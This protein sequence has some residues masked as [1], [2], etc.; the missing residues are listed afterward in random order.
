[1]GNESSSDVAPDSEELPAPP[2]PVNR[3]ELQ[4]EESTHLTQDSS[5]NTNN[6]RSSSNKITSP[7]TD[8]GKTGAPAYT[9]VGTPPSTTTSITSKPIAPHAVDSKDGDR[10]KF[11][12][13]SVE[14]EFVGNDEEQ[15]TRQQSNQSNRGMEQHTG[16]EDKFTDF[17]KWM[18]KHGAQFPDQHLVKYTE[19]NR[20]VHA[21]KDISGKK[22]NNF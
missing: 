20:G 9:K 8:P 18:K 13:S 2:S 5:Q 1:M 4:R 17:V 12:H 14:T 3:V 11:F 15:S 7:S 19:E 21:M 22:L 6:D 16:G 10:K